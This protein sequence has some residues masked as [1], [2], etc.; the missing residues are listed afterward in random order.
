TPGLPCRGGRPRAR[1]APPGPP[2]GGP[3][4]GGPPPRGAGGRGRH[5]ERRR[6]GGGTRAGRAKG[7]G[8]AARGGGRGAERRTGRT[9]AARA[10]RGAAGG[11]WVELAA[12][13]ERAVGPHGMAFTVG[14]QH[15]EKLTREA[16]REG[17]DCIV[18]VGG[19]GTLNEVVNG[20]FDGEERISPEAKLAVVP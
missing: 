18:A 4:P 1:S 9:A 20:F 3:P 17:Y 6:A 11:R 15:A 19:D 8:P 2:T 13:I 7:G 5:R 12:R 16:L 14:P 10:A